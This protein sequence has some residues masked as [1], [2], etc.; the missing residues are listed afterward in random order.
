MECLFFPST[1]WFGSTWE[2]REKR[3]RTG[4]RLATWGTSPGTKALPPFSLRRFLLTALFAKLR[5]ISLSSNWFLGL[6]LFISKKSRISERCSSLQVTCNK[7][8]TYSLWLLPVWQ[9]QASA[10]VHGRHAWGAEH[11][12]GILLRHSEDIAAL[13]GSYRSQ[14]FFL[15]IGWQVVKTLCTSG[16]QPDLRLTKVDT[17][18]TWKAHLLL[19]SLENLL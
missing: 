15:Q 12:L 8:E 6:F 10:Y 7:I 11:C 18:L 9:D 16:L 13:E 2:M 17:R 4:S 5:K 1:A 3:D 14:W 19:N